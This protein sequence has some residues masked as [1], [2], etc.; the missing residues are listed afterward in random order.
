MRNKKNSGAATCRYN[1]LEDGPVPEGIEIKALRDNGR[2]IEIW[3]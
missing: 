1:V 2:E 3:H